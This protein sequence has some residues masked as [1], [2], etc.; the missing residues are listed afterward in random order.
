MCHTW[1]ES[2]KKVIK[3]VMAS[4]AFTAAVGAFGTARAEDITIAH[5]YGKTGALEAY[6]KQ[7]HDGL[8]LGLEYATDGTMEI[9]GRRLVVIEKDTQLRPELGRALL[10]EAYGDDNATIAVGDVSSGVALAMLPV[11]EEFERLLIV[12]PAVADSITGPDWNRYIFRTSAPGHGRKPFSS[13][14]KTSA[15]TASGS[16]SSC[17][18]H[19]QKR[20]PRVLAIPISAQAL[21]SA[22]PGRIVPSCAA[23]ARFCA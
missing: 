1:E 11:A 17:C 9:D 5:V 22:L 6:A 2:I 16:R 7:S 18:C 12:E 19:T 13:M 21:I 8:L 20:S 15:T 23:S 10:A 4:I 3:A 14:S